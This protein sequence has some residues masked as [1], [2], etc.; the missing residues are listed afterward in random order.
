[1]PAPEWG[2]EN[3]YT[4]PRNDLEQQLAGIW[5]DILGIDAVGIHDD[6]FELGGHSL[7][8]IQVVA[9]IRKHV[10]S[11][12][13][14]RLLFENPT[15]AA[16][17]GAIDGSA[18]KPAPEIATIDR[19]GHLPL[20]FAQQRLWFLHQLMPDNPMYNVPWAQRFTTD[21]DTALLQQALDQLVAKHETLRSN[22]ISDAGK[23]ELRINAGQ[24]IPV[25]H[26]SVADE[27][28][29]QATLT[30]LSRK[31]FELDQGPLLTV[32]AIDIGSEGQDS[33]L[34][35]VMHHIISDAWSLD[36]LTRELLDD[37]RSLQAGNTATETTLSVQY[38]DYAAWQQQQLQA[39]A[40]ERQMS[41]WRSSL[42]G[43]PAVLELPT[44][45]PRPTAQSYAGSLTGRVLRPE[46]AAK[47]RSLSGSQGVT[48]YMT[49]LTALNVLLARYSGQEDIVVGTPVSG[50]SQ[51][52]L[53]GIIGLFLN[54]LVIRSDLSDSPSFNTLLAK[55][56]QT[57]LD[58]FAHQDLPFERLVE[59][60]QPVRDM[61]VSP[62]F[63]V[64]FTLQNAEIGDAGNDHNVAYE[65]NSA[66]FDLNISVTDSSDGAIGITCEYA[67]DLFDRSTIERMLQHYEILLGALS[68]Q[69]EVATNILPM[70]SGDEQQLVL[71]EWNA[72]AV[73]FDGAS[74]LHGLVETQ[75]MLNPDKVA[76]VHN[77]T[78]LTYRELDAATAGLATE[79][80]AAGA[81]PGVPIAVCLERSADMLISL[82]AVLRAGSNYVPLDPNYP[83]DRISY[84]L[85]DSGARVLVTETG[86]S[87]QLMT[88]GIEVI[89][90]D[91]STSLSNTKLPETV[92]SDDLAYQIYTSGST[93]LPKGVQ[94]EHSAVVNFLQSMADTPGLDSNDTLLSV[95]TLCFDISILEFFLP[96][97]V[98][99]KLVIASQSETADGF[100]LQELITR[101]SVNVMQATPA[102]WR[103]MLQ[104][105]WQGNPELKVLCGGETLD[106]SLADQLVT[107]NAELWN[108]YGPTETTV[109]SSCHRYAASDELITI[110]KPIANTL[111]YVLDRHLQALPAGI[112]GD[113]YIGGD[114]VARGYWQRDELNL[115]QFQSNPF[116][117]GRI[118]K[119]GDRVRW[120]N[121]GNLEVLGR[122]DFQVKL[123][124]FRI[125]LGEIES[126]LANHPNVTQAVVRL[127]EDIP[128]DQRLVAYLIAPEGV[129]LD[130]A[131]LREH[132]SSDLPD[133]M[134]P[135]AYVQLERF[136]LTPNGKI[137]RK[138][139]APPD[140]NQ[141][142]KVEYVPPR[143]ALEESLCALWGDVL[144]VEKAGI[145]DDFFALGG[146]SLIATQLVSRIRDTLNVELAL[147]QLFEH[148]TVAQLAVDITESSSSEALT[149]PTI[150]R[151]TRLPLSYA[152]QRLW[153][154]DQ[155]EP[156]NPVYN[157]PWSIR[158][159]GTLDAAALEAAIGDMVIRHET[160]RTTFVSGEDEP[161][162]I[163]HPS[164]SIPLEQITA[165]D[166]DELQRLLA[167]FSAKTFDLR[168]G[169]L[170]QAQ[171]IQN[172]ETDHVLT[173]LL[174]HI[175]A[176][177]WSWNILFR[178]L[179]VFYNARCAKQKATL[180]KLPIQYVDYCGWER[181]FLQG[182]ELTRQTD[183]WVGHLAGA[184]AIL[185][186]PTDNPRP[187][188]QTYN[189]AHLTSYTTVG[190]NNKLTRIANEQGCTPYMLL[191]A[192]FNLL[193]ARYAG[194]DDIVV[195]TPI[196]GRHRTEFEAL[197]G[198]F[199]NTMA[200]R[201]D[202]SG[203][204]RFSE[205]LSRVKQNSLNAYAH[206]DLPFEKLVEVL[207]P[208][209]DQSHTP[210]FQ[211]MFNYHNEPQQEIVYSELNAQ[212]IEPERV[213]AKFD[214]S[215]AMADVGDRF[216]IDFEYNTDLFS[217]ATIE[218]MLE[219][220]KGLLEDIAIQPDAPLSDYS[221]RLQAAPAIKWH[222]HKE[223]AHT[224]DAETLTA[225]FE[226]QVDINPAALAVD[227]NGQTLNYSEL[228]NYANSIA[229]TLTAHGQ[230]ATRVAVLLGHDAH[231]IAG[232]L[233]V[234]KTGA[235]YLP[236][237][238]R[239]PEQRL[240]QLLRLGEPQLLLTDDAHQELANSLSNIPVIC[241]EQP[242]NDVVH[243]N[244]EPQGDAG[245]VAY[246]LFTSGSSGTPKGVLQTHENILH[247]VQTYAN[248]LR[249]S[250]A[251]RLSL[252][253]N[254]AFDASIQDIF[255]ALLSGASVH[256]VDLR[257]EEQTGH[258]SLALKQRGITVLHAT[259]TVFRHLLD[260][261]EVALP[262]VRIVV[263]G[264]EIAR[265]HDLKLF[266][267]H[268]VPSAVF[269]NGYGLTESTVNLQYFADQST[270]LRGKAV[271]A[272]SPVADTR[273]QLIDR[274]G[275]QSSICGAITIESERLFTGY[276][277]LAPRSELGQYKTG[278]HARYSADGQILITG[279]HDQQVKIR[280]YRVDLVEVE[281]LIAGNPRVD[282]AAAIIQNADTDDPYLVAFV[283]SADDEFDIDALRAELR[284]TMP[285]YML[286][287][288]F[289]P[290]NT[291]PITSNGK[292]N[293]QALPIYN[294]QRIA[295]NEATLP[296]TANE[297][298]LHGIWL[299]LLKQDIIGIH[300]NFF[301]L[302]GHSLMTIRLL[303][304]IERATDIKLSI[305]DVFEQPTV[306]GLAA[307]MDNSSVS[308]RPRALIPVSTDEDG[309][310]MFMI[311]MDELN[312]SW[313]IHVS[314][315]LYSLNLPYL[316]GEMPETDLIALAQIYVEEMRSVQAQG[317]W[318]ITAVGFAAL[319][320]A[321]MGRQLDAEG[322]AGIQLTVIDPTPIPLSA[323]GENRGVHGQSASKP[324]YFA[325]INIFQRAL[326]GIYNRMSGNM[327]MFLQPADNELRM[328]TATQGYRPPALS[329]L[330]QNGT[331]LTIISSSAHAEDYWLSATDDTPM[332][333]VGSEQLAEI[334]T[335]L[336]Q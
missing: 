303:R 132:I 212:I 115:A 139:L 220:L 112:P 233:G 240:Q 8:A 32:T 282:R 266:N 218:T 222:G 88:D 333:Y 276:L 54:T 161:E 280:G 314:R 73:K 89:C 58:A 107:G 312:L 229:S 122:T 61:S 127:R 116:G 141:L 279:R 48:L 65:Y 97:T 189:G 149:I 295:S 102:T 219:S 39:E 323:I 181:H 108:M 10:G 185:E 71:R 110:G 245:D 271:P 136:P 153:F 235:H 319:V 168:D 63:Q 198:L 193:L 78:A 244:P 310:P 317:P 187:P 121:N 90:A 92:N 259:P 207:Q 206:Q 34:M 274:S 196:A 255:G 283:A 113:L 200:I 288:A 243:I 320:A 50:R 16:L 273:I 292:V 31:L 284:Q 105:G 230:P 264:G 13:T 332:H 147:R 335:R 25:D 296:E 7:L 138:A 155:L 262:A 275:S 313:Q 41:Y 43:A 1:L 256:P 247:H 79:L 94:I 140:Q 306:A 163:I 250:P 293:R 236:L 232:L 286:P 258:S 111:I 44:D 68:E 166:E 254:Y 46:L 117:D 190:L 257:N 227:D 134:L 307:V 160:L 309:I 326:C 52:A 69:P 178:E 51:P 70:L 85:E 208:T 252:F 4:A 103:M 38:V 329:P 167:K 2:S 40:V 74:T 201:T 137:D 318:H 290:L 327:P 285:G 197:I 26:I 297:K 18:D 125:E 22:F 174:H 12:L 164:L 128:G 270:V 49:M 24:Q 253:S 83:E 45:R 242:M 331:S 239:Q 315:P 184:P 3:E 159:T 170:M 311:H 33:A 260:D 199:L 330:L 156:G 162:Q 182:E 246:I 15:I 9:R 131:G 268:F 301:D 124:G 204:P 278:D 289:I 194:Q 324:L 81:G 114:G 186:L 23:P 17:A 328:Q 47:L 129:T 277:G 126:A 287:S 120:L 214:L 109:W 148:P 291:I 304:D 14:L 35:L 67:T 217:P 325:R 298:L 27:T 72:T 11:N 169:P 66:K 237:D 133:Y 226:R 322:G 56:K 209:R 95:T 146:H 19:D 221:L 82:L 188:V 305:A 100:A 294:P 98:G 177:G 267:E 321:E 249:I 151:S 265:T 142:A 225:Q 269:V 334:L 215:V 251:D 154:L 179:M 143:N 308:D 64:M 60:L 183:Y 195:G 36:L 158:L 6:F 336:W 238:S 299:I 59:E 202:L 123:R 180:P 55:I 99:A 76:L 135:S 62:I 87:Q 57:V 224:L 118:Y 101:H 223:T 37:Y 106:R 84:M 29:L 5:A 281:Q 191:F 104:A 211:V 263:L 21:F 234:L 203:N 216:W 302:G 192:A 172:T 96:L 30:R 42:E 300:D 176:D 20:S 144:G 241:I 171:L 248:A 130:P 173:L 231:M 80:L 91:Q 210:V 165:G 213:S 316:Q 86:L 119:T 272:G 261:D 157:L 75:M 205:L 150:D 93:G 152:Q 53:E 28:E 175:I 228:N 77:D 145:H